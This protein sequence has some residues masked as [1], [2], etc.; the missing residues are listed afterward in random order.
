MSQMQI[1]TLKFNLLML[2]SWL[3][4]FP[5]ESAFASSEVINDGGLVARLTGAAWSDTPEEVKASSVNHFQQLYMPFHV[6]LHSFVNLKLASDFFAPLCFMIILKNYGKCQENSSRRWRRRIGELTIETRTSLQQR[7]QKLR[8]Q[9]YHYRQMNTCVYHNPPSCSNPFG[10]GG[11]QGGERGS[12][13][14]FKR[15][16][17]IA[18]IRWSNVKRFLLLED[19]KFAPQSGYER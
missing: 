15:N 2:F 10:C 5:V 19:L 16:D 3:Q 8:I 6:P 4:L 12:M 13:G 9:F 18:L 11:N 1:M 14:R 7:D 17:V